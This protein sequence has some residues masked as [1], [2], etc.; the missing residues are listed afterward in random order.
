[1]KILLAMAALLVVLFSSDSHAD[2]ESDQQAV[3]ER[4]R[5]PWVIPYVPED[6]TEIRALDLFR[7][8][9]YPEDIRVRLAEG[10]SGIPVRW[11]G[12]V[13]ERKTTPML[14]GEAEELTIEHRY[15]DWRETTNGELIYISAK[16]EGY[17]RCFFAPHEIQG[18]LGHQVGDFVIV[19]GIPWMTRQVDNM[20]VVECMRTKFIS[21]SIYT[22][23]A[24]S[25]GR[26][27]VD[28]D[29]LEDVEVL[30]TR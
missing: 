17:F 21:S 14:G 9:I 19:Y 3:S 16:G 12:I 22:D 24:W 27:F 23:E 29:V 6:D 11:T 2:R 18:F 25:Y 30:S 13:V 7:R 10:V 8:D 15:W 26:E 28:H 20:I 4:L 5:Q 1:M